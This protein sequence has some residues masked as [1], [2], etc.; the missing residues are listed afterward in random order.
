MNTTYQKVWVVEKSIIYKNTTM[1]RLKKSLI[2]KST[3]L[4]GW[5][6]EAK[7]EKKVENFMQ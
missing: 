5:L 3:H 6:Q 1:A 7:L 4:V 2:A